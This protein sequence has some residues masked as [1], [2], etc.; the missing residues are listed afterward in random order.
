MEPLFPGL[1][2]LAL[3]ATEAGEDIEQAKSTIVRLYESVVD[4]LPVV[5]VGLVVFLV[6]MVGAR[7]VRS[8]IT[9]AGGRTRLDP[10]LVT[11]LGRLSAAVMVVLGFFVAAVVVFPAFKPG[12]LITGLGITSVALGF[13]LKDVL[14]NFVAGILLLWRRPF[15]VGDQIRTGVHEGTVER[16]DVRATRIRTYD[17]ELVVV[18]NGDVYT[19][20]IVVRTAYEKRRVQIVV[21]IGYADAIEEA[22]AAILGVLQGT[23]GVDEAPGPMVYVSKFAPSSIDLTVFFWTEAHQANVLRV[24]D[25]VATGIKAALDREGIDIPYPHVVVSLREGAGRVVR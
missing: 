22:R 15:R 21:G 7:L 18:P 16:L 6:F 25:R 14:Q 8:V 10:A 24:S 19:G 17:D 12:D 1:P 9:A 3:Q 23:E 20:S 5:G 2:L 13:A 4:R 11:L